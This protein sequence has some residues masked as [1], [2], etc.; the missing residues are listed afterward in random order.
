LYATIRDIPDIEIVEL[1]QLLLNKRTF[2]GI[3]SVLKQRTLFNNIN[4]LRSVIGDTPLVI[5]D[6]DPWESFIDSSL[7]KDAYFRFMQ[8]FNVK[9]IA[10]TTK[11]WA[12]HLRTIGLPGVFVKMWLLQ[13]Y[14][15]VGTP[16]IDRPVNVAF[17]GRLHSYRKHLFDELMRAG[18]NV[19]YV[20]GTLKYNDFLRLLR[21]VRIFVHSEDSS[22][23]VDGKI[24]NLNVGLWIKDIEAVSQGCFSIRNA[25]DGSDTY[26][27]GLPAT[28]GETLIK[29]YDTISDVPHIVRQIEIMDAQTRQNLIEQTVAFVKT[30]DEWRHTA[31]RLVD[32]LKI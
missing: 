22:I 16:F 8:A 9:A 20:P 18:V 5:Y 3:I 23:C 1:Q 2:D 31:H 15:H 24:F 7:Y 32:E 21:D 28:N 12:D 17:I 4:Q 10:V 26:F 30:I 11:F 13:R 6:Q 14:C 29:L 27:S 19:T 25:A